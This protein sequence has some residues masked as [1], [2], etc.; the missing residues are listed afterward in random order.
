MF[1]SFANADIIRGPIP[2]PNPI[3][4]PIPTPIPTY[5][6]EYHPSLIKIFDKTDVSDHCSNSGIASDAVFRGAEGITG[7]DAFHDGCNARI[8]HEFR[9]G[10]AFAD[11]TGNLFP[12]DIEIIS[13]TLSFKLNENGTAPGTF[14]LDHDATTGRPKNHCRVDLYLADSDWSKLAYESLPSSKIFLANFPFVGLGN[15][16]FRADIT[17][18]FKDLYFRKIPNLGFIL[19]GDTP[20]RIPETNVQCTSL[21]SDFIINVQYRL[22]Q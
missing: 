9:T 8:F 17:Q 21:M 12:T 14:G 6:L 20:D 4:R 13:A 19:F 22:P 3:P 5:K 18:K 2:V 10:V 11:I 7:Y 16:Q 15:G 1:F